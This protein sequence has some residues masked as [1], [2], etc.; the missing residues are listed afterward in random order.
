LSVNHGAS[1]GG[2]KVLGTASITGHSPLGQGSSHLAG[3][4]SENGT[5]SQH[6]GFT[7]KARNKGKNK[8]VF[9]LDGIKKGSQIKITIKS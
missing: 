2:N 3:V 4:N 5:T 7:A 8:A 6:H 9:S 1:P